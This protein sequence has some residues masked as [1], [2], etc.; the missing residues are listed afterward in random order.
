MVDYRINLS[1][2]L[3]STV[4]ERTRFYNGMLV[5]LAL[6]SVALV[7]V[8]YISTVNSLNFLENKRDRARLLV[9]VSAQTGVD[10]TAFKNTTQA[11]AELEA[12]SKQ[13]NELRLVLMHRRAQYPIIS[14]LFLDLPDSVVLQSLLMKEG[15]LSFGLT[16]PSASA[17]AGDPVRKLKTTW[18]QNKELMKH[19]VSI[20]PITGERRTIGTESVFYLKFECVLKK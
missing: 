9:E 18:G 14:N 4:E 7:F 16:M 19:V 20:R 8:I 2:T 13:L 6:C 3:T 5:Y 10:K 15:K 17:E 11:Y 1:K 12:Y